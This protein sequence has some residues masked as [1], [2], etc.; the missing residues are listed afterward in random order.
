MDDPAERAEVPTWARAVRP[1]RIARLRVAVAAATVAIDLCELVEI[2][3]GRK[4]TARSYS[5]SE[6]PDVH[7]TE[8]AT[9]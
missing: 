8:A 3:L 5:A 7:R 4:E 1:I 9:S 6:H 2:V